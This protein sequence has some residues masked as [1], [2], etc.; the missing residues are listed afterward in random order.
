MTETSLQAWKKR[1]SKLTAAESR[2]K[3]GNNLNK[4]AGHDT[5]G[6]VARDG[7]GRIASGTSTSGLALKLPGRVGDSSLVGSGFYVDDKIGAAVATGCGELIMRG[8]LSFAIVELMRA[9]AG[10]Q[11]A[12]EESI[13]RLIRRLG[14]IVNLR[15]SRDDFSKVAVL[16]INHQGEIGAAANHAEFDFAYYMAGMSGSRLVRAKALS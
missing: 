11:A 7:A 1:R 5:I 8:C 3:A 12:C 2:Y 15:D 6:V 9:G 4:N 16:A 10:P 14:D 13:S